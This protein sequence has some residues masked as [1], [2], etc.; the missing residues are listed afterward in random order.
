MNSY[1]EDFDGDSI[2]LYSKLT[3]QRRGTDRKQRYSTVVGALKGAIS[4]S[5]FTLHHQSPQRRTRRSLHM[6]DTDNFLSPGQNPYQLHSTTADPSPNLDSLNSQASALQAQFDRL[7]AMADE[8]TCKAQTLCSPRCESRLSTVPPVQVNSF[9]DP[10]ISVNTIGSPLS[11]STTEGPEVQLQQHL[12]QLKRRSSVEYSPGRTPLKPVTVNN[13]QVSFISPMLRK[14]ITVQHQK[15]HHGSSDYGIGEANTPPLEKQ[16]ND[17]ESVEQIYKEVNLPPLKPQK[18][19]SGDDDKEN[20]SKQHMTQPPFTFTPIASYPS[21]QEETKGTQFET[22]PSTE[23]LLRFFNDED[24]D[25]VGYGE[26]QSSAL[27]LNPAEPQQ[28]LLEDK[29]TSQ[30]DC[31][32][33]CV[34]TTTETRECSIL[35][36]GMTSKKR[37][38]SSVEQGKTKSGTKR[39]GNN[40]VTQSV[41]KRKRLNPTNP[42]QAKN[43]NGEEEELETDADQVQRARERA[44]YAKK[45]IE[46]KYLTL[47]Q[48]QATQVT[49][50][51]AQQMIGVVSTEHKQ[52]QQQFDTKGAIFGQPVLSKK[53]S[54]LKSLSDTILRRR[55][56]TDRKKN[57]KNNNGRK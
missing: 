5:P 7:K 34:H 11:T 1:G 26:K 57:N 40:Y 29:G 12:R 50:Q 21:A 49:N 17:L 53:Q 6:T 56:V 19:P 24:D 37:P 39:F 45:K 8:A 30:N 2:N 27:L 33:D 51:T 15:P 42:A 35:A 36:G 28:M 55:K 10:T 20:E 14:R 23:F 48:A 16:V 54:R 41:S 25:G 13:P 22:K 44:E 43:N 52:N 32:I 9:D 38:S 18:F 47:S 46:E 31:A 3:P 4:S